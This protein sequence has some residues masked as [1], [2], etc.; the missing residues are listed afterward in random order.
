MKAIFHIF[1]LGV[2]YNKHI[3]EHFQIFS[4]MS[5]IDTFHVNC[6]LNTVHIDSLNKKFWHLFQILSPS[7]SQKY[8]V[9]FQKDKDGVSV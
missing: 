9:T 1:K 2:L 6:I 3:Y 4:K 8:V 5:L 7:K